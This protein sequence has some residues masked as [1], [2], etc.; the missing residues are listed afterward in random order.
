MRLVAA[1]TL[2][3][4]VSACGHELRPENANPP[5][6]AA[7]ARALIDHALPRTLSDRGGWVTDIDAAFTVLSLEAKPENV[8]AVVAV[9]AQESSFHVDPVIPGLPAMAWREIDERSAHAGVPL[10][11]LH[12]VLRLDSRDG[13]SYAARIDAARTEKDLSDIYE[14]FIASVPLG[15]R[16]FAD[17]NPIRT[18]GPMQVNVAFAERFAQQRPYPY[19][20]SRSLEDELFTRRGSIYFGTAHLLDYAAPYPDYRYRFADYNAGQYASRNAAWQRAVSI[21]SGVPLTA[22]GALLG[23]D[24][25]TGSTETALLAIAA[26][27]HV[28]ASAIHAALEEGKS[29]KFEQNA[30][31]RRVFELAEQRAGHALPRAALPQIKLAGPK[32]QRTLTTQWYAERVE[33]RYEHCLKNA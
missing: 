13:R 27:L 30:L 9:I 33:S 15:K 18:R 17:H 10:P 26:R 23:P 24:G 29:A 21:A 22:D 25:T 8:C 3:L 7:E 16:L 31:Y 14:D 32:I 19:P 5:V 6:R 20:I 28:S 12:G 4:L 2:A 1:L 11:L